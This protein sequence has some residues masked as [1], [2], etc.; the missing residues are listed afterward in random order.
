MAIICGSHYV[1][2]GHCKRHQGQGIYLYSYSAGTEFPKNSQSN[3][4]I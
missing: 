4:E 1:S 2:I 3:G